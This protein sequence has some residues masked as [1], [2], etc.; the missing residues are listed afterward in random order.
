[1]TGIGNKVTLDSTDFQDS[2]VSSHTP[3]VPR[4]EHLTKLP[5]TEASEDVV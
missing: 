4:E 1:M 2:F 5:D 3:E